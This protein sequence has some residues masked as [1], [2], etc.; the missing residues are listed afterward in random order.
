M[1]IIFIVGAY[2]SLDYSK[3]YTQ[4][5]NNPE[6]LNIKVKIQKQNDISKLKET[7]LYLHD[8]TIQYTKD[9]SASLKNLAELFASLAV[10]TA[11]I[12]G[13]LY[14]GTISNKSINRT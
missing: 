7:A 10:L 1:L 9:N 5:S 8:S 3:Q 12:L 11:I 14:K 4:L 2:Y 13:M 6:Y